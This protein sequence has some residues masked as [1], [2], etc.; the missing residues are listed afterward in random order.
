MSVT[1]APRR[2]RA[3]A[4][5]RDVD[6]VA[7]PTVLD[8]ESFQTMFA[9]GH[10]QGEHVSIV[11]PTGGGKST[12]MFELCR[13]IGSRKGR[14]GRPSRVTIFATKRRDATLEKLVRSGWPIIKKWP[15]KFGEE[16]CVVWPRGMRQ[17]ERAQRQ[18][19]VFAPLFD[20]IDE[21]G[22]QAVCIDEAA[23]FERPLPRGLSMGGALE[24]TW[25]E[26]RSNKV[27]LIAGTQRPRH[28]SRAMWSEPSWIF[29]IRPE[30]EEDLKRVAQLSGQKE[31]VLA[32]TG[33][34][35]GYEFLCVRRQRDG[36][37]GLYVSKVDQKGRSA[38]AK[39]S[40]PHHS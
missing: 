7:A 20:V 10:R 18:R 34:L 37:R 30:D 21:E 35:G 13:V 2:R 24:Q 36:R 32:I 22:G 27:T 16:H 14:D 33:H 38:D 4:R 6:P 17:S 29:I 39:G 11:G 12:L 15:P 1:P 19:A 5:A 31:E 25:T 40:T 9:A 3:R 23:Y 28:V 8:W 26:S